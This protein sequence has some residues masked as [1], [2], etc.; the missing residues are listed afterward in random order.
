MNQNLDTTYNSITREIKAKAKQCKEQWLND[1]VL[2]QSKVK[3]PGSC[4]GL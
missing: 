3:I 4:S 2:R 1:M